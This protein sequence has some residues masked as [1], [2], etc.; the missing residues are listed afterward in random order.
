MVPIYLVKLFNNWLINYEIFMKK[1]NFGVSKSKSRKF[2]KLTGLFVLGVN[3]IVFISLPGI[4]RLTLKS[5]LQS[6]GMQDVS[7]ENIDFNIFKGHFLLQDFVAKIDE[8]R[9]VSVDTVEVYFSL[10]GLW[11]HSLDIRNIFVDDLHVYAQKLENGD[12][13]VGYQ[14]NNENSVE[15]ES[16]DEIESHNEEEG[17]QWEIVL[18]D[19]TLS[20]GKLILSDAKGVG[21]IGADFNFKLKEFGVLSSGDVSFSEFGVS[22]TVLSIEKNDFLSCEDFVVN[23]FD[24]SENE[25]KISGVTL[26]S[27]SAYILRRKEGEIHAQ[28][29][30]E[31]F[32]KHHQFRKASGDAD[33]KSVQWSIGDISFAG[34][35][36][37]H[38]RDE[39]VQPELDSTFEVKEFSVGAVSSLRADD[40]TPVSIWL[41]NDQYSNIKL[42]GVVSPLSESINAR[43]NFDVTQF[44]IT[45]FSPY[46][47]DAI[48][49]KAKM[50]QLNLK[51]TTQIE[52]GIVKSSNVV[53]LNKFTVVVGDEKKAKEF[54]DQIQMSLDSA[55]YFIRD[56]HDD[57]KLDVPINGS[58]DD[59]GFKLGPIIRKA[60]TK[61]ISGAALMYFKFA[62][63]PWGALLMLGE[64]L[65]SQAVKFDPV[66]YSPGESNLNGNMQN[67][68]DK[69]SEMLKKK[70]K[71]R[72]T[73]CPITNLSDKLFL[74]ENKKI[75]N[76]EEVVKVLENLA[77][78]RANAV[79]T[80]LVEKGVD[81]DRLF[82]CAAA[83]QGGDEVKPQVN[84]SF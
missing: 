82:N 13:S 7:M 29:V 78:Q 48:G 25:L 49:Y 40:G 59:P 32:L 71:I 8:Y 36:F 34:K 28:V 63:Q 67:Y 38:I 68:L 41:S 14:L 75:K 58:L 21:N 12:I 44:D 1:L 70:E 60:S 30:L 74:E 24:Y 6:H 83:Y 4:I 17:G 80:Y 39:S 16:H 56:D 10:A 42:T 18:E 69:L 15:N 52:K 50:G 57:V 51:N 65:G 45:P 72:L 11:N 20:G 26:S 66:T 3:F 79:K 9:K 54:E 84:L 46:M 62:L 47:I 35:N 55:L 2:W 64:K 22:E 76:S 37:I 23:D 5:H 53:R 27:L 73:L 77:G 43:L 19:F 81:S 33:S 31:R 61:A